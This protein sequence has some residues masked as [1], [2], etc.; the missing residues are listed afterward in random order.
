MDKLRKVIRL[1]VRGRMEHIRQFRLILHKPV[2][3]FIN[4]F[5]E[6]HFHVALADEEAGVFIFGVEFR[7][8]VEVLQGFTVSILIVFRITHSEIPQGIIL[9]F[10]SH[11]YKKFNGLC[12]VSDIVVGSRKK[13]HRFKIQL[14][15]ADFLQSVYDLLMLVGLMPFIDLFSSMIR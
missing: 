14:C 11:G 13:P 8:L 10:L 3:K 7:S 6:R 4:T 2:P 9:S 15:R 1:C 12:I 5:G